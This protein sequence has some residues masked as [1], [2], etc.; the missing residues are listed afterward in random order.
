MVDRNPADG[1]SR[2]GL[3][4][5]YV[6]SGD[7]VTAL[8]HFMQLLEHNPNYA[9]AYF[10]GGADAGETGADRRSERPLPPRHGSHGSNGRRTHPRRVASGPKPPRLN[11]SCFVGRDP[12]PAADAL[13]GFHR[14]NSNPVASPAVAFES[15]F[16]A[17]EGLYDTVTRRGFCT[18]HAS[19]SPPLIS[20]CF[21]SGTTRFTV[22]PIVVL[23]AQSQLFPRALDAYQAAGKLLRRKSIVIVHRIRRL[24]C[25]KRA[26]IN[27]RFQIRQFLA[28]LVL[29]PIDLSRLGRGISAPLRIFRIEAL[30]F[31]L[32]A[33]RKI[34]LAQLNV[35]RR[36]RR[37][38]PRASGFGILLLIHTELRILAPTIRNC[39]EPD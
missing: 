6:K 17:F 23:H 37:R 4:M 26:R 34:L 1:F 28:G 27:P 5:E 11:H 30:L 21:V 2:Y 24:L 3:A 7:L 14:W 19:V 20:N 32:A 38:Y 8:D 31:D 10:H 36:L 22:L 16:G 39:A 13:V 33:R 9:A 29:Q 12:C 15:A 25:R 35:R 18:P